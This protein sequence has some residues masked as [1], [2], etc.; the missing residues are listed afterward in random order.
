MKN[1]IVIMQK[2]IKTYNTNVL[3]NLSPK[4]CNDPRIQ[5][6]GLIVKLNW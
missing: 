1:N 4:V 6:N 5:M 2:L 3:Q